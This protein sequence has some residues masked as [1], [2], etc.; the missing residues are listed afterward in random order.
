VALAL[1]ACGGKKDDVLQG[2]A[3][4]D[5]IY[6]APRDSGI[7]EKLAVEEGQEVKAGDLIFGLDT[8]RAQAG[9][10]RAKASQG[11]GGG[12]TAAREAAIAEARASVAL[13]RT[14]LDRSKAL[15]KKDFVSK[16]RLD[17]DQ[18]ALDAAVAQLRAA[19]AE[20]LAASRETQA[21]GADV[22]IAKEQVDDRAVRAPQAGRVERVFRRPG[23][24]APAG[25]PVIALLPAQNMKLRFFAPQDRLATLKLGDVVKVTCDGCAKPIEAKITFI[26]SEP[27][28]TPPVIYSLKERGKLVYL[29]EARPVEAQT[30][31]PGQPVDVGLTS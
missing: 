22:T 20:K 12:S 25:E 17:Q 4:A 7:V 19:E 3:E 16:A 15:Y 5:Y 10:D 23:E 27:Q 29:V 8:T 9:L 30:L 2:Y 18:S 13:A 24:F 1:T 21:A 31:R 11:A 14:N 26:A 6:L 28:F